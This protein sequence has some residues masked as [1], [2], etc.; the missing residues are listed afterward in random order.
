VRD[1]VTNPLTALKLITAPLAGS[2]PGPEEA[3]APTRIH[4][5]ALHDA[6]VVDLSAPP[7]ALAIAAPYPP[8]LSWLDGSDPLGP[9]GRSAKIANPPRTT[10]EK[11]LSTL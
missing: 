6:A 3:L 1:N 11:L 10:V 5:G 8:G 7:K 9:Q 2:A 4:A